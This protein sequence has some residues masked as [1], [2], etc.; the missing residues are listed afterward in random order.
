MMPNGSAVIWLSVASSPALQKGRTAKCRHLSQGRHS[1]VAS[2]I[3]DPA[4]DTAGAY[5]NPK[6]IQKRP[7]LSGQRIWLDPSVARK[8]RHQ[9]HLTRQ[10]ILC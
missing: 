5:C 7:F 9:Y 10:T 8:G 1:F 4:P 2:T 6:R 3:A